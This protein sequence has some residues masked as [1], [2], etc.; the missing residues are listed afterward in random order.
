[1]K[2]GES[3][4]FFFFLSFG[5]RHVRSRKQYA[6]VKWVSAGKERENQ[7]QT[8][9]AN[10]ILQVCLSL[11][12]QNKIFSNIGIFYKSRRFH[13]QE[14][15]VGKVKNAFLFYFLAKNLG[16]KKVR[17]LCKTIY[18]KVGHNKTFFKNSR[19]FFT[20]MLLTWRIMPQ[21]QLLLLCATNHHRII[22]Y[23]LSR[24]H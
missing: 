1:M 4:R 10:Q 17:S 12:V 16:S 2:D 5:G 15:T 18:H 9:V 7:H 20:G 11:Y 19:L 23:T 22:A 3:K 8:L 14:R 6:K 21:T 24:H 13:I